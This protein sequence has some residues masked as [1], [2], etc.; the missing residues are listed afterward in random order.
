MG[1]T[2][3]GYSSHSGS[4]YWGQDSGHNCT[5]YVA[6]AE[7]TLNGISKPS[8]LGIGNADVWWN[9]ASGHV[10]ESVSTPVIGAVAWWGDASW[11]GNAGHVAYVEGVS[12][13]GATITVSEDAFPSGPFDWRRL[14][15][16][17]HS[18]S[19]NFGW[20]NGFIY[21]ANLG[22]G[23]GSG[24]GG[25]SYADGSYL[26]AP[27]GSVYLVA[28]GAAVP[29]YSWQSVG[30]S[31][32]VTAVSQQQIDSMPKAPADGTYVYQYG[33]S[34]VYEFAGGAPIPVYSW[35]SV[36]G[37]KTAEMIPSGAITGDFPPYPGDGTYVVQY[38]NASVYEFAGGAPIPVYSWE[39]V[40]GPK[41][42][43]VIPQGAI[44][45]DFPGMPADGTYVL[46]Y[47]NPSVYEMIGG[48]PI[49]VYSWESIGGPQT[50]TSI[51]NGAIA[52]D[53]RQY[54]VDGTYVLE[55]GSPSVYIIAGGA[56]LH[57]ESWEGVGGPHPATVM[58]TGSIAGSMLSYP[59][60]GTYVR[61]YGSGEEF[62]AGGGM[63]TRVTT[64]PLPPATIVDD[65]A[66]INQ[67]G[68]TE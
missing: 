1:Y 61:G 38:G 35:A 62:L 10:T 42:A 13:G 9:H 46:E 52:N 37:S 39:S 48:A 6:Y 3:H 20:P 63:V 2:D 58:P 40:G 17:D 50:V 53:F 26:V 14:N 41:A 56:A 22:G 18:T 36:G 27:S 49:P 16:T 47:G 54:P 44:P 33:N 23:S 68:G 15:S 8:W 55:Y 65:W 32:G 4:S 12:N 19:T 30:G 59:Q 45:A 66:I 34:S 21:V 31:H 24:G 51:P 29:V 43:I 64:T 28:G 11:N 67:L 25:G 57:V 60:D 7:Q 5:N